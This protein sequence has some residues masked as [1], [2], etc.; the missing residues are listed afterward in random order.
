M[1]CIMSVWWMWSMEESKSHICIL[2]ICNNTNPYV[3]FLLYFLMASLMS[4]HQFNSFFTANT[5]HTH[6]HNDT[7]S[8]KQKREENETEIFHLHYY[9]LTQLHFHYHTS[10]HRARWLPFT[11]LFIHHQKRKK[12]K[13]GKN[14]VCAPPYIHPDVKWGCEN[15]VNHEEF[16]LGWFLLKFLQ[17]L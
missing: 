3:F 1:C 12:K 15:F 5:H 13:Y 2:N 17:T 16:F 6:K 7:L 10:S 14:N 8:N 4:S 11:F 9:Y